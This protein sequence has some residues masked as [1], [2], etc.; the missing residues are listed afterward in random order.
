MG[1]KYYIAYEM[2]MSTTDLAKYFYNNFWNILELEAGLNL[3]QL[4]GLVTW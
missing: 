2:R 4:V 3:A 1:E